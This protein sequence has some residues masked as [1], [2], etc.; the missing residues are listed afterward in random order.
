MSL[1]DHLP[2]ALRHVGGKGLNRL[3]A[4]MG[5]SAGNV[6]HLDIRAAR[7]WIAPPGWQAGQKADPVT[8]Q[9]LV[10]GEVALTA[11]ADMPRADV[12]QAGRGPLACGFDFALP[13]QLRDG[14]AHQ[15]VL[16]VAPEGPVLAS[17][18]FAADA[19][20]A[21]AHAAD[22]TPVIEGVAYFNPATRM[23]E[24][25]VTGA[26]RV[27]VTIAGTSAIEVTADR[28]IA[29]FGSGLRPGF[30]MALPPALQ[31]GRLRQVHVDAMGV[32][33]DGSPFGAQVHP[34]LPQV[35]LHSEGALARLSL[36]DQDGHALPQD[37]IALHCDGQGVALHNATFPRPPAGTLVTISDAQR[38]L[39][40][41]IASSQR[42]IPF[43]ALGAEDGGTSAG[44]RPDAATCAAARAAFAALDPDDPRFDAAWYGA[45]H[46]LPTDQAF[47][48]Y[49]THGAAAG[50]SPAPWFD[51]QAARA[52][53][54][55][56]AAA[57]AKGALP[58]L[59][60][61]TLLPDAPAIW[62]PQG[63]AQL[64]A[65][66]RAPVTLPR[67]LRRLPPATPDTAPDNIWA[68][69]LAR[70]STDAATRAAIMEDEAAVRAACDAQ[71]LTARPLVSVIMPT[72]NRAFTI[73][74][75]I[76]SLI[77]QS[78]PDWELLVCDDASTDRTADVVHGF[79][80]PRIRYLSLLKS[81][82]A[83][84]RNHGLAAARGTYIAYLD[85]DN[86][87]HPLYLEMMLS[88]L[89]AE[90]G[91]MLAYAGYLDTVT[92]GAQ[93]TL[94]KIAMAPYR[95]LPLVQRNFI[96]LNTI[97]HHRALYDWLGGFDPALPR[98]QDWDLVT[99]YAQ[100]AR[101]ALV[102]HIGVYYRRNVAWG[103]VTHLFMNSG[104]RDM[105]GAK[106][107]ARIDGVIDQPRLPWATGQRVIV[108]GDAEGADVATALAALAAQHLE[109]VDL[110]L[111]VPCPDVPE[112][113]R[114]YHIEAS[115]WADPA[116][117]AHATA[118]D[119][120]AVMVTCGTP[121]ATPRDPRQLL[122]VETDGFGLILTGVA[123][124][125]PLGMV[126]LH[127]SVAAGQGKDVLALGGGIKANLPVTQLLPPA[128]AE[129]WRAV[130]G[131]A[132]QSR[133]SLTSAQ[134]LAEVRAVLVPCA[135]ADLPANDHLLLATAVAQGLPLIA[136]TDDGADGTS[137]PAQWIHPKAVV[138]IPTSDAPA[139]KLLRKA[140]AA[141]L[142]P[143]GAQGRT[144]QALTDHP[145][146]VGG[147]LAMA[148]FCAAT[149]KAP[150]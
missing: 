84:A 147:R 16:R 92:E 67:T 104:A 95:A 64:P 63:Y 12:A 18:Q 36:W 135:L 116:A 78:Y 105:V 39:G 47:V 81:N 27:S 122:R 32:I 118:L 145:R 149:G 106:I 126:P 60:A 88:R 2:A 25:W 91:P 150:R 50:H 148:L 133:P 24:G 52:A 44:L 6:D 138:T 15:L 61:L 49:Q 43:I 62:L 130:M 110:Y 108:T 139:Y 5:R 10:D 56:A 71:P 107:N 13:R 66:T 123:G 77:S 57:V 115:L 85:S 9:V 73:G 31:D 76:Q 59:F 58:C 48:H 125:Y 11:I 128:G 96:D 101:P 93:V 82:G 146:A 111:P 70:L 80:D 121:P 37:G 4:L 17:R 142:A 87:W 109:E 120:G 117:F 102:P 112:G 42:D 141:D 86:I 34:S 40:R 46:M 19:D 8:L 124:R 79:D 53:H 132:V 94:D 83:G 14:L 33:L 98:L 29:G 90:G 113:V 51:E 75:A 21:A 131:G 69:W 35:A 7:G 72:W 74:E 136:V 100:L 28:E 114:A 144:V 55:H 22:P 103:Q 3:R 65:D 23:I 68:A 99:R 140:L 97:M 137:L 30:A 89:M 38:V 20:L 143:V 54:P 127:L 26:P 119:E 41:F 134:A 129:G 1:Q 45:R